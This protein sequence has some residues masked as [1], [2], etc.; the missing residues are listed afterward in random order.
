MQPPGVADDQDE[1]QVSRRGARGFSPGALRRRRAAL[2]LTLQQLAAL[3]G[4]GTMTISSWENALKDPSPAKL[5][6]VA[7]ALRLPIIDLMVVP[8]NDLHLADLRFQV[9]LTQASVAKQVGVSVSTIS[10][11]ERG[12]TVPTPAQLQ[13]LA[14]C[15]GLPLDQLT[16]IATRTR[17]SF[18]HRA[19]A[20]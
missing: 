10:A 17:E 7:D 19:S 20:L 13:A 5:A 6:A 2:G 8:E 18:M 4:V 12:A 14:D 3:S 11:L 16:T 15:F 9:G 1:V